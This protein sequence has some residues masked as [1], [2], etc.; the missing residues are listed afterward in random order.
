M[1]LKNP[2]KA[3]Y[4]YKGGVFPPGEWVDVSDM[5]P[6]RIEWLTVT[7]G[8]AV[9]QKPA[10][11]PEPEAVTVEPQPVAPPVV[12]PIKTTKKA[13]KTRKGKAD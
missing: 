12:P 11:K 8:F 10:P 2:G 13:K 7:L 3:T 1:L 4:C 9:K 6:A 5:H